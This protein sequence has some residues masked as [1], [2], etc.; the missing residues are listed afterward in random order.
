MEKDHILFFL[1]LFYF[2]LFLKGNKFGRFFIAKKIKDTTLTNATPAGVYNQPSDTT[3]RTKI[4]L[5]NTKISPVAVY[6]D[7]DG[8]EWLRIIEGWTK[9]KHWTEVEKTQDLSEDTL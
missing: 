3:K 4:L 6:K 1:Q 2:I 5:F 7:K 8:V 9:R